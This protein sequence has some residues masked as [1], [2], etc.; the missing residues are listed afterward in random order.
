MSG[1]VIG[2]RLRG[3]L[4]VP[5]GWL[6]GMTTPRLGI[7]FVPTLP[8]EALPGLARLADEHLDDL[9]VWEDC[10]KES[11][12]ASAAVA[13][14]AT[15]RVRVGLGLM[16]APLRAPSLAAMEIATLQRVFPGRF[17]PGI[18]HGVQDWMRQSGV[19][20]ESP[21]TLLEEHLRAVRGLLAGETVSTE[22]RYVRLDGVRLDWPPAPG[23]RLM[24]GGFGPRTVALAAR[25]TDGLLTAAGRTLDEL[26]A[27]VGLARQARSDEGL[28]VAP[29]DFEVVHG[30]IVATGDE[31]R[32]RLATEMQVWGQEPDGT[33]GVAGD[34]QQ[35][36]ELIRRLA[37]VGATTVVAQPTSDEP[38]L[39][40]LV[41]FLGEQVRPLL[42]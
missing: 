23:E 2:A 3:G 31:A 42:S 17:V 1:E 38:D 20:V 28:S 13:L 37:A 18:G 8:P 32:E 40:G 30:L 14:S 11:G 33:N 19:R 35:V 41:A 25:H 36:A 7:C 9:W 5:R 39:E 29:E 15:E 24:S 4:S 6:A 26:D 10:F 16:P 22:G 27:Q 12:I 34:A 21:M